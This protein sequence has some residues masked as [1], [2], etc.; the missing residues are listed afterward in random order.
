MSPIE[1]STPKTTANISL[2]PDLAEDLQLANSTNNYSF[3]P[4]ILLTTN[5]TSSTNPAL[6]YYNQKTKSSKKAQKYLPNKQR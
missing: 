3:P 1:A 5:E 6:N 2:I 4:K